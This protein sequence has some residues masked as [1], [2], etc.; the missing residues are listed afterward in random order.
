MSLAANQNHREALCVLADIYYEGEYIERDIDK[1]V[2]YY[3][4]SAKQNCNDSLFKL[5]SLHYEG[6]YV[7]Y[8]I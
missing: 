8:D 2:H 5:G 3:T 6:L 1:V 7:D 4:L